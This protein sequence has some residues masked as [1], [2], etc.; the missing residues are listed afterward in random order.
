[1]RGEPLSFGGMASQGLSAGGVGPLLRRWRSVRRF[2]QLDLALQAGVSARHLSFLENGRS[3]PS[4]EMVLL[5]AGVLG[6]PLR[7]QNAL[8]QAAGYAALYRETPLHDPQMAGI[9]QALELILRRHE[10]FGAVV[11][12][13]HWT[14]LLANEGYAALWN[15]LAGPAAPRIRA[16]ELIP[17]PRPNV[18]RALFDPAGVR[19]HI[20]NWEELAHHMLQRVQREAYATDDEETRGLLRDLLACPG[21]PARWREVDVAQAPRLVVPVELMR[22]ADRL[23]LFSTLTTLGAPQ[24]ITLHELRI[25]AFHPADAES[26]RCFLEAAAGAP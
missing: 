9:R 12:D 10:P 1:V 18:L 4:R 6:V 15:H 20:A 16:Y 11:L 19:A 26:E 3:Q 17:A 5:L 24:D 23:R 7:E 25:E 13:R 8:L 2:S 22:G 21:V 14:L